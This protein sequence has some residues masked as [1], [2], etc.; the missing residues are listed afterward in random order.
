MT[1]VQVGI[2]F[3]IKPASWC[4][5]RRREAGF[6]AHPCRSKAV[7]A[8][9]DQYVSSHVLSCRA[10]TDDEVRDLYRP[11]VSVPS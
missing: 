4:D 11:K 3:T 6:I 5:K 10:V 9:M 2:F 1:R 8:A 7:C